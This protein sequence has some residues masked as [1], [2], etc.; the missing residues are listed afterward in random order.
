MMGTTKRR[1]I[2]I[3]FCSRK[4]V[5]MVIRYQSKVMMPDAMGFK[6]SEMMKRKV[7]E[8]TR[9]K[10]VVN[11]VDAK[12][13]IELLLDPNMPELEDYSILEDGEEL[14]VHICVRSRLVHLKYLQSSRHAINKDSPSLVSIHYSD[15][16][17]QAW[18]EVY[19]RRLSFS[20]CIIISWQCKKQTVCKIPQTEANMWLLKLMLDNCFDSESTT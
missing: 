12:T 20:G 7:T 8:E 18:N 11:D 3:Q 4:S 14:D 1:W 2:I 5:Y 17:E 9:E 19:N 6:P 10:R 16:A 15:Y 13:S